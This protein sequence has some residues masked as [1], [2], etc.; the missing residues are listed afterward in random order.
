MDAIPG[1][2]DEAECRGKWSAT[3]SNEEE[4][5]DY[6]VEHTRVNI[7]PECQQTQSAD[8]SNRDSAVEF[9]FGHCF[10]SSVAAGLTGRCT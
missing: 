6:A 3:E 8:N 5:S 1:D 7:N 2:E 9:R 4:W 10:T